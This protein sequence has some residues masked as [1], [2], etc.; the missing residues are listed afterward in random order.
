M[1]VRWWIAIAAAW[2][3]FTLVDDIRL[4][5]TSGSVL[6]ALGIAGC[7]IAFIA[8]CIDERSGT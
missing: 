6:D 1:S 3:A 4:H 7:V 5:D 8:H 2:A